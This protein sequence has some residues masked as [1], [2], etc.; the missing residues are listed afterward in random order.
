MIDQ[1]EDEQGY[2]DAL[3]AWVTRYNPSYIEMERVVLGRTPGLEYGGRLDVICEIAGETWLVDYK[4]GKPYAW[5][6]TLQLSAYRFADGIATY[7]ENCCLIDVLQPLPTIH[8]TAALYLH[9]DGTFDFTE[10]PGDEKAFAA[11]MA[12]R[13]VLGIVR[14]FEQAE[15]KRKKASHVQDQR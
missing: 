15:R 9:D 2:L 1:L 6:H 7:D 10:Y 3:E 12:L 13:S 4:T 14:E 11:F 8:H 5:E